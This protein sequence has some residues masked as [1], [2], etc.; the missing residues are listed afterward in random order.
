M[1]SCDM[2]SMYSY[3]DGHSAILHADNTTAEKSSERARIC[4]VL[5]AYL[6]I[7]GSQR[8]MKV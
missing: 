3:N 1:L 6:L 8:P 4:L 5:A 7:Y 2:A